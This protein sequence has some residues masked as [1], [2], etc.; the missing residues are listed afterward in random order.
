MVDVMKFA[1]MKWPNKYLLVPFEVDN[2]QNIK[3]ITQTNN[4]FLLDCY[5]K[6]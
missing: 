1:A 6:M 4:L 3:Y 2:L 5:I